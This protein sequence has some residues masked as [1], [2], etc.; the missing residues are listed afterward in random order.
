MSLTSKLVKNRNRNS[1]GSK[2][3][4]IGGV[5]AK[6]RLILV[7]H[8]YA[9]IR[10][11]YSITGVLQ[12]ASS[13][14]RGRMKQILSSVIKDVQTGAYLFESFG[15]FPKYFSPTFLHLLEVGER[16]AS[17]EESLSQLHV[18]LQKNEEFKQKI[19]SASIYPIFVLVAIVGLGL[20]VAYFVLPNLVPLFRGLD[21]E[22]PISTR[23]LFWVADLFENH[24]SQI[25]WSLFLFL[26]VMIWVVRRDFSKPVTHWL[27]L[28]FPLLGSLYRKI[29][30]MQ[31]SRTMHS[32]LRSGITIDNA[33]RNA[34]LSLDN[35]YYRNR[36]LAMIPLIS[37]GDTLADSIR[38][39]SFLFGDFFADMLDLG[40]KTGSL[41][42][43][44]FNITEFY[45]MEVDR[46]T[47][48]LLTALEPLL[49]IF[50]GLLVA[51]VALSILSPIY[52]LSGSIR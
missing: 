51:F 17:L 3:I 25:L 38:T 49:L 15:R 48:D 8:L 39:E 4:V 20:S 21:T 6:E 9:G 30:I 34:A 50:V 26:F 28:R 29:I 13:Q 10:A 11:G 43:S 45:E 27:V 37:K 42:E 32:L 44:F 5:S 23:I 46:Q 41:E 36:L 19:R 31:F 1:W 40:E 7:E 35:I 24:G 18:M 14:A 12:L 33:L 2:E 47:K 52:S 16:S 22:L